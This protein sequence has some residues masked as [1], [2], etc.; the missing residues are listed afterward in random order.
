MTADVESEAFILDRAREPAYV[1][2]VL[3][4]Y[5]DLM[6]VPCEFIAGGETGR[7]GTYD[8]GV[9]LGLCLQN[10]SRYPLSVL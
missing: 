6:P 5:N 7:S 9:A 10:L 4:Q 8:D 2:R 1:L 3:L